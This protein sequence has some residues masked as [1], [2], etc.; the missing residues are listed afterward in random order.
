MYGFR[1]LLCFHHWNIESQF[2][3]EIAFFLKSKKQIEYTEIPSD[4]IPV[5][6]NNFVYMWLWKNQN[7]INFVFSNHPGVTISFDEK[8]KNNL[9][10]SLEKI[11]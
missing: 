3:H 9:I 5:M 11:K 8:I 10:E 4:A 7:R 2:F 1:G 6:G